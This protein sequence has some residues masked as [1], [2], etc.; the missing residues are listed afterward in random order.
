METSIMHVDLHRN[1]AQRHAF[2]KGDILNI[3]QHE[4]TPELGCM[5]LTHTAVSPFRASAQNS[6]VVRRSH[7]SS[8]GL[9]IVPFQ[10][11]SSRFSSH[12]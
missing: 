12:L 9:Q 4:N 8:I 7:V 11:V 5:E 10:N 6:D 2:K 1:K 3:R